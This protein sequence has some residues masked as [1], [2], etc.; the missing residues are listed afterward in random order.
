M[1]RCE[2]VTQVRKRKGLVTQKSR[3]QPAAVNLEDNVV[4]VKG[5]LNSHPFV[6]K[7]IR[8]TANRRP[9][10]LYTEQQLADMRRFCCIV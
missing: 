4:T 8:S 5:V 10:L 2:L 3:P 9:S 6:R 7:V 1:V